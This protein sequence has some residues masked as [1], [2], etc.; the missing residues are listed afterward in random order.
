MLML[1]AMIMAMGD[2]SDRAFMERVYLDYRRLMYRIAYHILRDHFI[3]ED[4]INSACEAL[5]K[6][7]SLLRSFDSCKLQAYVVFT[8]RNT[9]LNEL[10]A[11]QRRDARLFY[12]IDFVSETVSSGDDV[13]E[14]LI[15]EAEISELAEALNQLAPKERDILQQKYLMQKTDGEIAS[16]YGIQEGSVRYYLTLARRHLAEIM[17]GKECT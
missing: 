6:K 17:K 13:S 9:A 2:E 4:V 7:V 10:K 12:D 3:T 5:C 11:R 1:P 14:H 16:F 8:C 15:R